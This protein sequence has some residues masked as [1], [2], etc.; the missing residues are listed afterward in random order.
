M[1]ALAQRYLNFYI[2]VVF[3][4]LTAVNTAFANLSC[5]TL[6][7]ITDSLQNESEI[8][9]PRS[10]RIDSDAA[11]TI[12]VGHFKEHLE[13]TSRLFRSLENP[14]LL[15][16][17]AHSFRTHKY[18]DSPGSTPSLIGRIKQFFSKDQDLPFESFIDRAPVF[19][20]EL[21]LNENDLIKVWN[22]YN[23]IRKNIDD[24]FIENRNQRYLLAVFIL[25]SN[26]N[27]DFGRNVSKSSIEM[28][29]LEASELS[30]NMAERAIL[31]PRMLR[32]LNSIIKDSLFLFALENYLSIRMS[33]HDNM[34][35]IKRMHSSAFRFKNTS[36][37]KWIASFIF[38]KYL[39]IQLNLR[40]KLASLSVN[41]DQE[42]QF[43]LNKFEEDLLE[44][45]D[46]KSL[47][48]DMLAVLDNLIYG[49]PM[50]LGFSQTEQMIVDGARNFWMP[51]KNEIS[52]Q[53]TAEQDLLRQQNFESSR[54]QRE[55]RDYTPQR[56]ENLN[57]V[58][59]PNKRE[60]RRNRGRQQRNETETQDSQFEALYFDK[61]LSPSADEFYEITFLRNQNL[62]RQRVRF[63]EEVIT[64]M[65]R[66]DLLWQTFLVPINNG[67]TAS[68]GQN[69]IKKVGVRNNSVSNNV[70]EVRPGKSQFRMIMVNVG[71]EWTV[72]KIVHH[73][74]VHR[75][76]IRI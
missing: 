49:T 65:E 37:S 17:I 36:E 42:R 29:G 18:V 31:N 61:D 51:I 11:S 19:F 4:V 22:I 76:I 45:L 10:L 58:R 32:T 35:F 53:R 27:F 12:L 14:V 71:D 8:T 28:T 43:F 72:I 64:E 34:K 50:P 24:G 48:E 74:D 46:D 39:G 5:M 67:F 30:D 62:G 54:I 57:N 6:L 21:N 63:S 75:T 7:S 15:N 9:L 16:Q 2:V 38:V 44:S 52:A 26:R 3:T 20:T 56:V 68:N 1:S 41:L 47:A 55:V 13:V 40:S 59:N 66:R 70:Y 33:N 69:G 60:R 23:A 25:K 73:D